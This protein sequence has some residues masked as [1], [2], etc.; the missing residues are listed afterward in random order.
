MKCIFGSFNLFPSSKIDFWPFLKLQKDWILVKIIFREIH[1]FDFTRFFLAWTFLNFLAHYVYVMFLN[2]YVWCNLESRKKTVRNNNNNK[3]MQSN[4][5]I[6]WVGAQWLKV[7]RETIY[8]FAM[9]YYYSN[10]MT[11]AWNKVFV[12]GMYNC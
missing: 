5:T 2:F 1:L 4:L 10:Y 6:V 9:D 12:P 8:W 3:S 7:K 11:W